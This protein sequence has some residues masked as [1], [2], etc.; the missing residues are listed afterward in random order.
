MP[1]I[2]HGFPLFSRAATPF[3]NPKQATP[4]S[5]PQC[6]LRTIPKLLKQLELAISVKDGAVF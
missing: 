1:S 5:E 6:P 4:A 3:A 2:E